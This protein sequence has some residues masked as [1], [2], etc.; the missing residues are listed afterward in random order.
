MKKILLTFPFALL[1]CLFQ[2]CLTVDE[3]ISKIPQIKNA[4]ER[5]WGFSAKP[6][7]TAPLDAPIDVQLESICYEFKVNYIFGE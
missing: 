5:G 6:S 4:P 1:C 7:F 3:A 2:G